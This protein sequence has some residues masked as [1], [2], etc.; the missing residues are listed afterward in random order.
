MLH[1]CSASCHGV[2][3]SGN[4]CHIASRL[5]NEPGPLGGG[6]IVNPW[7][8]PARLRTRRGCRVS[9]SGPRPVRDTAPPPFCLDHA[10]LSQGCNRGP[11]QPS[12]PRPEM[13]VGAHFRADQVVWHPTML[14]SVS[15]CWVHPIHDAPRWSVDRGLRSSG[16]DGGC[17]LRP[18]PLPLQGARNSH[19]PS[20]HPTWLQRLPWQDLDS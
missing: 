15:H 4:I 12:P 7:V 8:L 1:H 3:F 14:S 16:C 20:C 10:P 17:P 18:T 5:K 6:N 13:V 9:D 11:D 19:F 2:C